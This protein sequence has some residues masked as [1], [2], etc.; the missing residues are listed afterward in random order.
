VINRFYQ[1]DPR[2]LGPLQFLAAFGQQRQQ[3]KAIEAG[4]QAQQNQAW[5]QAIGTGLQTAGQLGATAIFANDQSMADLSPLERMSVLGSLTPGLAGLGRQAGSMAQIKARNAA[6]AGYGDAMAQLYGAGGG[7]GAGPMAGGAPS[8]PG[9]YGVSLPDQGMSQTFPEQQQ[10][11]LALAP[12]NVKDF[13]DA[14]AEL[15]SLN[16]SRK[17]FIQG[18]HA[19][20][21]EMGFAQS[22]MPKYNAAKTR[23]N[24]L[25]QSQPKPPTTEA[26]LIAAGPYNGG[27]SVLSDGTRFSVDKAGKQHFDKPSKAEVPNLPNSPEEANSFVEKRVGITGDGSK[28]LIQPDGKLT[29]FKET[30][31]PNVLTEKQIQ[32]MALK[33]WQAQ[34]KPDKYGKKKPKSPEMMGQEVDAIADQIRS[35]QGPQATLG[36]SG[37]PAQQFGDPVEAMYEHAVQIVQNNANGATVDREAKAALGDFYKQFPAGI[38]PNHPRRDEMIQTILELRRIAAQRQLQAVP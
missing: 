27:F 6:P 14:E 24:E 29:P 34:N 28:V 13:R 7:G 19:P 21:E 20:A 12:G 3:V 38:P 8:V 25:R 36:T 5:G 11:P 37:T 23:Y 22:F 35:S 2:V 4:Q 17:L 16:A 31:D 9:E 26:E 30:P 10:G 1:T 32:D 15:I 33:M 18:S